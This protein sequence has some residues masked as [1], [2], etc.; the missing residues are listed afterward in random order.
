[1]QTRRSYVHLAG[2]FPD[3]AANLARRMLGVRVPVQIGPKPQA[4]RFRLEVEVLNRHACS[5]PNSLIQ[6]GSV[7]SDHV[8]PAQTG[9]KF[10]PLKLSHRSHTPVKETPGG[11]SS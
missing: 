5:I 2:T 3:D 7:L 4:K 1:M 11:S 10:Y 8:R 9:R 6:A